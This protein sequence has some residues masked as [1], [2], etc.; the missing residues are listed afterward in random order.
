MS[1]F[2]FGER[3][4]GPALAAIRGILL[5]QL[6]R[7]QSDVRVRG[8]NRDAVPQPRNAV[9]TVAA[10]L[11]VTGVAAGV[12]RGPELRIPDGGKMK[13]SRQ[14]A[15]DGLRIAVERHCLSQ[16]CRISGVPFLP[17]SVAQ[18]DRARR[19]RRILARAKIA[20]QYRRHTQ[21]L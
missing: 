11:R 17:G 19:C 18:H 16:N 4:D 15:D 2:Q 20:A 13:V 6:S 12:Q 9:E 5:F 8:L 10:S 3:D 21:R 7:D 1:D 14:H